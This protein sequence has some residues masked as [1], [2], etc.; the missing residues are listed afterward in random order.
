MSRPTLLESSDEHLDSPHRGLSVRVRYDTVA[1]FRVGKMIEAG[2]IYSLGEDRVLVLEV[3]STEVKV[4]FLNEIKTLDI[5][6]F[7]SM[8]V[9]L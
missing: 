9:K 7:L 6:S 1:S 8:A 4:I 5:T 3:S 2:Q